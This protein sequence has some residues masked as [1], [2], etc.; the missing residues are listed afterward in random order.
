MGRPG[1]G[2]HATWTD[3]GT[4][5]EHRADTET[6]GHCNRI[7]IVR[8]TT[9]EGSP[10]GFCRLCMRA[11]CDVCERRGKCVP[12]ERRLEAMEAKDAFGRAF[13]L[14]RGAG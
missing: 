12:F 4:G 7:W 2:G 3:P 9:G 1:P 10:G 13:D 11:V 8:A 6:C 14:L 5:R